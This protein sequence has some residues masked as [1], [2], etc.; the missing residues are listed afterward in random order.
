MKKI[1]FYCLSLFLLVSLSITKAYANLSFEQGLGDW[2]V[3][4]RYP[5][6]SRSFT[7]NV[8]SD[9]YSE[10]VKSI[11]L[12]AQV[13]NG[14]DTAQNVVWNQG[15]Y[16]LTGSTFVSVDMTDIQKATQHYGWGWGM[17]AY[18]VLS[19]GTHETYSMLWNYHEENTGLYGP[20][21]LE[22]NL[23]TSTFTGSDGTQWYR[24]SRP[25]NASNW[26]GTAY[27]NGGPLSNLNLSSV[28]VGVVFAANNWNFSPQTLFANALVDNIQ[29][30]N[31]QTP[32]VPEFGMATGVLAIMLSAGSYLVIKS[33]NII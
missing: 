17:D 33:K 1:I 13:T 7:N 31:Q 11:R 19:D 9:R 16:N 32:N 29:I 8:I 12:G 24:Y 27:G 30:D 20:A 2:T 10:G 15:N 6:N 26:D 5:G 4:N 21:G 14:S 23:Y 25:L 28:K 22:D 18:L 3:E